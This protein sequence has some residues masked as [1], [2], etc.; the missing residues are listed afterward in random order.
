MERPRYL[1]GT[2]LNLFYPASWAMERPKS[3]KNGLWTV[4]I[5]II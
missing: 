3:M 4:E 1:I 2:I 5:A